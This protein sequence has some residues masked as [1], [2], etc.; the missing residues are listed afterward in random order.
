MIGWEFGNEYHGCADLPGPMNHLPD[1]V[2]ALGTPRGRTEKDIFTHDDERTAMLAFAKE[3]RKYDK[4]R[5]INNGNGYPRT[6][7]WHGMTQENWNADT[8]KQYAEIWTSP[9]PWPIDT[10]SVHMYEVS[11]D[12]FGRNVGT[13]ELL[14]ITKDIA[15]R[16]NRP[17]LVCEFGS[18]E[19]AGADKAK[20]LFFT[21][22]DDS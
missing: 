1:V 17:L 15:D 7:E 21:E 19:T 8:E 16:A 12:R 3:V 20:K 13:Y 5:M 11:E 4:Y 18:V 6:S 9:A 22:L 10:L 14:R 2:P